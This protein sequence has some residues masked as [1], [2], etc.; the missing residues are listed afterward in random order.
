MKLMNLLKSRTSTRKY[1]NRPVSNKNLKA[2]IEAGLWGPSIHHF[3]PWKFVVVKSVPLV[4]K[5]S[6]AVEKKAK[7]I[8]IP[9]FI[10]FPTI[11]TL[12]STKTM[13][14]IYNTK[15]FSKKLK[16]YYKKYYKNF[17]LAE[18]SSISAAIQNMI[19][20]AESINLGTCWLDLPLFSRNEINKIL[21]QKDE[22]LAVLTI[23]YPAEQGK[24]ANRK[25][26]E[27][28]VVYLR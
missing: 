6:S 16:K 7:K 11:K 27:E 4:K 8:K 24:R 19:L 18:I 14:C 12:K 1:L 26:T 10:F 5:I 17:E 9:N 3:Q 25:K 23:G 20:M 13:I 15:N 28:S 2:I 22:L 21:K